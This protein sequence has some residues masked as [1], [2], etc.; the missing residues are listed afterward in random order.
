MTT[1]DTP[2]GDRPF[3]NHD[4]KLTEDCQFGSHHD[5]W[6]LNISYSEDIDMNDAIDRNAL[7]GKPKPQK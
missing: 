5:D 2:Q 6:W 7:K 3:Q 4:K 1:P